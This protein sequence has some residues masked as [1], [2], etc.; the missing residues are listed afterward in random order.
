MK[1]HLQA[2]REALDKPAFIKLAAPQ[3]A[4]LTEDTVA[5]AYDLLLKMGVWDPNDDLLN[6][7]AAERTTAQMVEFNVIERDVPF[8]RWATDRFVKEAVA[9]LGRK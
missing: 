7:A 2:T 8:E 4:P 6:K 5:R 1:A 9:A 3:L